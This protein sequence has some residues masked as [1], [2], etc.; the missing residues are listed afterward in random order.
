[1]HTA[2]E[3]MEAQ[4]G[5]PSGSNVAGDLPPQQI[6]AAAQSGTLKPPGK[7]SYLTAGF[8]PC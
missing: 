2:A 1:M 3:L 5:A 8:F 6:D 7:N 4:E